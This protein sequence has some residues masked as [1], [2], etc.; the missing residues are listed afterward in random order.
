MADAV[1][2]S[3]IATGKPVDAEKLTLAK[4]ISPVPVIV[5]SGTTYDNLPKLWKYADG[6][7]VGTWIKKDGKTKNDIDLRKAKKLVDFEFYFPKDLL[8][9]DV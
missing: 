7:I 8:P 3:G 4:K 9:I 2:V 1:I 6:F 5:G